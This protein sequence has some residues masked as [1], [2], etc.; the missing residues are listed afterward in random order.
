ME[1]MEFVFKFAK[2]LDTVIIAIV[3]FVSSILVAK[4]TCEHDVK[5][6]LYSKKIE[7]YERALSLL[8]LKINVCANCLNLMGSLKRENQQAVLP[9][10]S[11]LI[12][13]VQ[14]MFE[15]EKKDIDIAIISLYVD[16]Q[17]KAPLKN[18]TKLSDFLQKAIKIFNQLQ[19]T[20]INIDDKNSLLDELSIAIDDFSSFAEAEYNYLS[21]I[22]DK[23]VN[24]F[25]N[26]KILHKLIDKV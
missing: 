8:I 4:F 15:L 6:F 12:G 11:I 7:A 2:E 26:D 20:N 5:K 22:Y 14:Q 17:D 9:M 10:V 1:F 23:L 25:R 16:I 13:T 3:G 18:F 19:N 24:R 21:G